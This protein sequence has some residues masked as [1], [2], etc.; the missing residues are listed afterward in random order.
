MKEYC[1]EYDPIIVIENLNLTT[2]GNWKSFSLLPGETL[3]V[4]GECT[5]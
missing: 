5:F 3:P 2:F 4:Y 1:I